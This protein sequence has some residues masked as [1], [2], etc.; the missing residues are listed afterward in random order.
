MYIIVQTVFLSIHRLEIIKN[1]KN[2]LSCCVSF[3]FF[4]CFFCLS[5]TTHA[6]ATI[7]SGEIVVNNVVMKPRA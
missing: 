1:N 3:I 4:L 5:R 2:T 6:S 7:A